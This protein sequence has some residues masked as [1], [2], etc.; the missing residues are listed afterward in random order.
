[1]KYLCYLCFLAFTVLLFC[2]D[3]SA[4]DKEKTLQ[5]VEELSSKKMHG[6]GY[7]KNGC[8]KAA[9]Y[10]AKEF[11]TIGLKS[12]GENYFQEFEFDV[13][14]FPGKLIVK[15]DNKKLVPGYDYMIGP[16]T[17]TLRNE[18]LLYRPDSLLLNDTL[19]F[20]KFIEKKD[21]SDKMLVIDY[22]QI[23]NIEIKVFYI[24]IMR[25][26]NVFGGIV[27]LIPD[28]LM[29]AV[30]MFQQD[31]PVVKIKRESFPENAHKIKLNVKSKLLEDYSVKNVIGYIEGANTDEFV[32]FTAHYDHLGSMGRD[33]YIP[34]AQDNASG[35]AMLLD[36]AEYY[37]NNK[38]E[39]SIAIMLF[40][41][42]EAGLL[43]SINYV[44]NPLFNP[45]NIK[46]LINL[47]MVGTG[48]DGITIVN[49]GNPEYKEI[50]NLFESINIEK[51]YFTNLKPRGEAA[52]SDHYP[53]HA[54]GV[55][56][57]FIYTM[58]GRTYYH[59]PEDKPETLTFTGYDALFNLLLN[60][61][62]K[63]E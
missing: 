59:N 14:T 13:N 11:E 30:R 33:V 37:S 2:N 56:A 27:E 53:F 45:K 34:G 63:Y 46:M 22:K 47:D 7:V 44:R 24:N 28:D 31:Y 41:G 36:I 35:S 60:F 50:W 39:Y 9:D 25:S 49:G 17:P 10:L 58:G 21:F 12:F 15:I 32:V 48:D 8:N 55:P 16:A 29:W 42:E 40:A 23:E 20:L 18:Y 61:V 52:N 3:I 51:E 4:Q 43:G 26:N 54:I 62:E 19:A 1:M 6:R 5:R 57:V 38:P